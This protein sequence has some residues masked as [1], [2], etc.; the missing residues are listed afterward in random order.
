MRKTRN[1]E[2]NRLS[3][4]A[5]QH[6]DKWPFVVV[7]DNI[8]S[9]HNVGAVFRTADAFRVQE[10]ILC[11]ITA[12][13]PNKDI[14]KTALGASDA[15]QWSYAHQTL[16]AIRDLKERGFFIVGL[17]QAD[18]SVPLARFPIQTDKRYALVLGHEV[19]GISQE[20]MDEVDACVEIPQFGTK[21]SLNISVSSGIVIWH[22]FEHH[23][24]GGKEWQ[25]TEGFQ[26]R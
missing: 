1:E 21:H 13:P 20:V 18:E 9:T 6:A 19:N 26:R 12:C 24:Q 11:G 2:L 16:D 7:L 10:L 23:R 22:F 17:E 15:V 14:R 25:R 8:R 3:S 4:H 5:F